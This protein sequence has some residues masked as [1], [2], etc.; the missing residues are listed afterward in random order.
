MRDREHQNL[1]R[2]LLNDYAV[3]EP[4]QDESLDSLRARLARHAHEGDCFLLEQIKGSVEGR[5][6]SDTEPGALLLVPGCGF[7]AAAPRIRSL[8]TMKCQCGPAY[9]V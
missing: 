1:P 6:K 7:T 5:R 9:G 2:I 4:F 3:R 8:R